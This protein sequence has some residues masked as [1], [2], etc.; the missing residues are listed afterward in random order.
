MLGALRGLYHRLVPESVRH[1]H[2]Y[3]RVRQLAVN[4][5]LR[6]RY[7]VDSTKHAREL[8]YWQRCFDREAGH[9]RNDWYERIFL[10][11]AGEADPSFLAGKIVVDFGCGPRGTLEWARPARARI[12]VDVLADLYARFGIRRHDMIYVTCSE[13]QI[14]LPS[15]YA[16]V[17]F[18]LNALD[19]VDDLPA[20]TSEL[21]RILAPGGRLIGSFN[22]HEPRSFAEPQTL[23]ERG[24]D[25]L[26]FSRLEVES[27]R[28]AKRG[29]EGAVYRHM[30]EPGAESLSPEEPGF[31]WIRA[32]KRPT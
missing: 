4:R 32:T 24:L 21:D 3:R 8:D 26:L 25:R 22:L 29:P 31:L 11:M 12:G 5:R 20:M 9:L 13:E 30:L 18:T 2:G 7:G 14:P 23:T 15:G 17:V 28:T 10:A 16:D 1:T 27:R 6:A 19:H